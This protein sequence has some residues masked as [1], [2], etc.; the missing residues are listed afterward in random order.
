MTFNILYNQGKKIP[1]FISQ[2]AEFSSTGIERWEN[3][4]SIP[5]NLEGTLTSE[6]VVVTYQIL[7]YGVLIPDP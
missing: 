6:D 4:Q 1:Y 7:V 2:N 3:Y 5:A